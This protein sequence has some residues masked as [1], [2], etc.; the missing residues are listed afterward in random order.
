MGVLIYFYLKNQV[1][2]QQDGLAEKVLTDKPEDLSLVP[3]AD[4]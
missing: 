2:G 1:L 4:V 3:K